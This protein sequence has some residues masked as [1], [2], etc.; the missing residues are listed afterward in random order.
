MIHWTLSLPIKFWPTLYNL[1]I[2]VQNSLRLGLLPAYPLL[3][4]SQKT[5]QQL[6]SAF[7]PVHSQVI[8]YVLSVLGWNQTPTHCDSPTWLPK[9]YINAALISLGVRWRNPQTLLFERSMRFI[10][11]QQI[12]PNK[13]FS[14][15]TCQS[16]NLNLF[17]SAQC[18]RLFNSLFLRLVH[19][20][21]LWMS[22]SLNQHWDRKNP[23]YP[24]C[25]SS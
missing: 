19:L 20:L 5:L 23:I 10:E 8:S 14:V 17:M 2:G 6:F 22:S 12:S 24:C 1:F 13:Y 9:C 11:G 21:Y 16:H 4:C 7:L 25:F 15:I 3:K 18:L